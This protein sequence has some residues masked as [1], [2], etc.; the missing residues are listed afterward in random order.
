M[1]PR[2]NEVRADA[3]GG[4]GRRRGAMIGDMVGNGEIGFVAD[5]ADDRDRTRGE[6]R[7]PTLRR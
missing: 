7:V 4:G 3:L 6:W 5:A 1:Q 2:V